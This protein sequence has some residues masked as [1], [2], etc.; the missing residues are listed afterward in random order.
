MATPRSTAERSQ[1]LSGQYCPRTTWSARDRWRQL[2]P[3]AGATQKRFPSGIGAE[4]VRR[5]A[6]CR[7]H[8]G[9]LAWSR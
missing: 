6:E 7:I 1:N 2:P 4:N 9:N 3:P 5:D 8:A